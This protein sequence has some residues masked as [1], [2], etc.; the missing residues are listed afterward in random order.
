[1]NFLIYFYAPGCSHCT[2]AHGRNSIKK[3]AVYLFAKNVRKRFWISPPRPHDS[4]SCTVSLRPFIPKIT[5]STNRFLGIPLGLLPTGRYSVAVPKTVDSFRTIRQLQQI[6][7]H[8]LRVFR[9][10]CSVFKR[11]CFCFH[12]PRLASVRYK[13]NTSWVVISEGFNGRLVGTCR[14]TP[15]PKSCTGAPSK[16]VIV[17]FFFFWILAARKKN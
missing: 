15:Y 11:L 3:M 14:R 10:Q 7:N 4:L 13:L 16:L 17:N 8:T 2:V 9:L 1:M 6:F 12:R 5:P